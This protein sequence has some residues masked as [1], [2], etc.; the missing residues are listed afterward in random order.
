MFNFD[1][2]S[3]WRMGDAPGDSLTGTNPATN[4]SVNVI[5]DVSTSSGYS[6]SD[7]TAME[8]T[9]SSGQADFVVDV[10]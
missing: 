6:R 9:A 4:A 5:K 7:G 2:V 3:W 8:R 10:P 1:A